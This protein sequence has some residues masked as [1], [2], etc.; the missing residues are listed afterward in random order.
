MNII[1]TQIFKLNPKK[2]D[3]KKIKKAASVLKKGGI[4]AFPTETVYGLAASS[5]NSQAIDKLYKIK[6]RPKNKPFPIQVDQLKSLKDFK[7]ELSKD[8]KVLIDKYWPGPLTLVLN[9]KNDEKIGFRI[10]QNKISQKLLKETA[11]PLCVPSANFSGENPAKSAKDVIIN[12]DGII[13][14]I[15]DGGRCKKAIESTVV[16]LTA[17]PYKVLREAAISVKELNQSL[18]SKNK[19]VKVKKILFV[20][21]GN[22]CRSVM[23]KGLLEN[24]SKKDL[25]VQS[26]GI[27][28]FSGMPPT[29][30]T[31]KT[32][33]KRGIDVS[34][35][36]A[37]GASASL[38]QEADLILVMEPKHKD[39]IIERFPEAKN[40]T[41]LLKE[42]K[43]KDKLDDYSISDPIGRPFNFYQKVYN[44]IE[45][46][47]KRIKEIL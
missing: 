34:Q 13:E 43:R 39:F 16:D 27:A 19:F 9:S 35:E 40:R 47:I 5:R 25:I 45:K 29:E 18:K 7:V 20:C 37:Q 4:V 6:R 42:Y 17:T 26:A 8:A 22:S 36:K 3:V 31:I 28:V 14:I 24:E 15:I 21:T 32:M 38:L 46:E 2:P 1:K 12:F 10:P 23:A 44:E 33:K 41:H 11:I 30:E